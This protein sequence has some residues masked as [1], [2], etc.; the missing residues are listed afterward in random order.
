[1]IDLSDIGENRYSRLEIIPWW[2]QSILKKSKVLI[3]GCGA[4]GNEIIKNLAL[5]GAG[6]IFVADMDNIDMSN[7]SRSILFR[8]EDLGKP[9]AKVAAKRA[10]EINDEINI[11]YYCGNVFNLGIGVFKDMDIIICGLDN[12][13]ARLFVNQSC[14]K[15]NK[16]WIDGAIE[17]LNGIARMFIPPD[18]ACY[19]CTFS[20]MDYKLLNRRKSCTLIGIEEIQQGKIPTTPSISSIIAGVQVQEAIKYLHNRN[21]MLS[22]NGK[23][24]VYNGIKN[25]SY[26]VE[27]QK[28]DDCPSHYTFNNIIKTGIDFI[29]ATIY[30]IFE[31]GKENFGDD[32]FIIEFNNEIV[33]EIRNPEKNTRKEFYANFNTIDNDD[34]K[35]DGTVY[36]PESIHNLKKDSRL[37]ERIKNITI[38]ELKIPFNDILALHNEDYTKEIQIEFIPKNI[39]SIIT[40]D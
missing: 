33:Y 2:E 40:S 13:E 8:K 11:G 19:E 3:I 1:M 24:L 35:I 12:R 5:L 17:V 25:E 15:A 28:K 39:F 26:I 34:L 9:K 22:L 36:F 37:F 16:P 32:K 4:L 27:Y 21:E 29:N 23:G 10:K 30:D 18:G 38:N 14:W 6:N 7:L 20:E 31:Y